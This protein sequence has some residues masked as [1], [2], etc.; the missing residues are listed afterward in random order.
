MVVVIGIVMEEV[1]C[2]SFDVFKMPMSDYDVFKI[3][4]ALSPLLLHYLVWNTEEQSH[5]VVDRNMVANAS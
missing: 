1:S 5:W 4:V 3:E 2:K